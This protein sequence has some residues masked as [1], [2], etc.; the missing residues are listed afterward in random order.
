M[1]IRPYGGKDKNAGKNK[2]DPREVGR[3]IWKTHCKYASTLSMH[4]KKG[5]KG[6]TCAKASVDISPYG[7]K[8]KTTERNKDDP[9]R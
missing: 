9:S 2:D 7:R 8:D 3:Y 5:D 4:S 6:T 1:A